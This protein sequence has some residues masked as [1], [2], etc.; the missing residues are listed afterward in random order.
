M[1]SGRWT[2]V[3]VAAPS[4]GVLL[5]L[6]AAACGD[7]DPTVE[8]P[9]GQDVEGDDAAAEADETDEAPAG[10]ADVVT[11][12]FAFEPQAVTVAAGTTLTWTNEDTVAHTVTSGAPGAADGGFDERLE[13][14]GDEVSVTFSDAGTFSYFCELHPN[15]TGE[16]VVE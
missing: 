11:R 15:M 4:L 9:P 7:D 1:R 13:A 10:D 16:V 6:T 12:D 8:P 5:A 14:E 3:R 2:A